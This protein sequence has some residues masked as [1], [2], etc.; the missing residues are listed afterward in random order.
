M[1]AFSTWSMRSSRRARTWSSLGGMGSGA[2][3]AGDD[4]RDTDAAAAEHAATAAD[5]RLF[6]VCKRLWRPWRE[7]LMLV[8]RAQ[9]TY[10]YCYEFG[11]DIYSI[12]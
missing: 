5:R 4:G 2:V 3:S 6:S 9:L 8:H 10:L 11:I 12:V 7:L 1:E